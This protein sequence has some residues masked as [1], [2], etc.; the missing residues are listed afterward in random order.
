[1]TT[2]P[3]TL[4]RA[5]EFAADVVLSG[6][7]EA[8]AMA[9]AEAAHGS[10]ES[11]KRAVPRVALDAG[12]DVGVLANHLAYRLSFQAEREGPPG[13]L[14]GGQPRRTF[15]RQDRTRGRWYGTISLLLPILARSVLR[16]AA[17]STRP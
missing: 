13:R 6:R 11:L 14:T 8:L 17:Y 7:A 12:V 4:R 16:T 15:S 1:M 5:N 3:P 2:A 10:V 9:C